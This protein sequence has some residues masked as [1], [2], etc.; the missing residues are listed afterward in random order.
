MVQNCI[1][2]QV[3]LKQL[4]FVCCVAKHKKY[5]SY[6]FGH[7]GHFLWL[8][9]CV[10]FIYNI[11]IWWSKVNDGLRTYMYLSYICNVAW[12]FK[13]YTNI[14]CQLCCREI[15][16]LNGS[17][18]MN[19][20]CDIACGQDH[21]NIILNLNFKSTKHFWHLNIFEHISTLH[22]SKYA[23]MLNAF[24]HIWYTKC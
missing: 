9:L 2:V 17:E 19:H 22:V 20:R 8:R 11:H 4:L 6:L 24:I 12:W 16:V 14:T 5:H 15:V 21:S 10:R 18:C 7:T 3:H 23:K 13:L 1:I